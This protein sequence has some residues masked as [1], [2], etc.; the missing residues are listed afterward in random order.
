MQSMV[1]H[2]RT[3]QFVLRMCRRRFPWVGKE[4]R[5]ERI[6]VHAC[7]AGARHQ[8]GRRSCSRRCATSRPNGGSGRSGRSHTPWLCASGRILCSSSSRGCSAP[9]SPPSVSRLGTA[10]ECRSLASVP[11]GGR[12]TVNKCQKNLRSHLADDL[13]RAHRQPY[14]HSQSN[15][16]TLQTE[17]FHVGN[18][19]REA[20][21]SRISASI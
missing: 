15:L 20:D 8:A 18:S 9:V 5:V 10:R 13:P 3:G 17:G 14:L 11:E 6:D 4:L 12:R 21:R 7:A 2:P 16:R 1:C 19:K